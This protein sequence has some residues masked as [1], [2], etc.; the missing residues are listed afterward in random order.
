MVTRA[1]ITSD[2]VADICKS[3]RSATHV[4]MYV[5]ILLSSLLRQFACKTDLFFRWG[6]NQD[7]AILSA[8]VSALYKEK[9]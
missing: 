9:T 6:S 3:Y 1:C 4:C 5:L 2:W 7:D 8:F